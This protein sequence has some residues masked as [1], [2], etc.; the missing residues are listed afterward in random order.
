MWVKS[1]V[2]ASSVTQ[3]QIVGARERL[4]GRKNMARRKVKKGEKSPWGQCLTR[5][6]PN[7]LRRS[8]FWL[9]PE[10]LCF[11]FFYSKLL[12]PRVKRVISNQQI[13]TRQPAPS[14]EKAYAQGT[15]AR[16]CFN[17]WLVENVEGDLW[18]NHISSY[19][20]YLTDPYRSRRQTA[21]YRES[22]LLGQLIG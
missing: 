2:F 17:F 15:T 11:S 8:D 18:A 22:S 1:C 13:R 3:G 14:A 21:A 9:V 12:W 16:V 20:S 6:V 5:H 10:N 4:N 7:G 19:N